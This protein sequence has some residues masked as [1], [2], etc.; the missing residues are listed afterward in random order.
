MMAQKKNMKFP[1]LYI[2]FLNQYL[3]NRIKFGKSYLNIL[4]F[5]V[6]IA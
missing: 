5:L 4:P 2:I 6:E 1:I 3:Q